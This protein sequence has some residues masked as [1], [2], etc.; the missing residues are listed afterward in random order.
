MNKIL[1][2]HGTAGKIAHSL[3]IS[4]DP[5]TQ[6]N[7]Y[8]IID[9]TNFDLTTISDGFEQ[10]EKGYYWDGDQTTC[11]RRELLSKN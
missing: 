7:N 8:V 5:K 11:H 10:A 4:L 2:S 9:F 1:P 6:K 3:L